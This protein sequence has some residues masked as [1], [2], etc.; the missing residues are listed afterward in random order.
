M[1]DMSLFRSYL[2][3][4]QTQRNPSRE[5]AQGMNTELTPEAVA[6]NLMTAT[7][8]N[9]SPVEG[10][11]APEEAEEFKRDFPLRIN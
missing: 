9:K 10:L 6:R 7:R 1:I 2:Q 5:I 4:V 8:Q 3:N 11:V